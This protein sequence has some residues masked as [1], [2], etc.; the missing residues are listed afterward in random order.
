[1]DINLYCRTHDEAISLDTHLFTKETWGR[2]LEAEYHWLRGFREYI[3]D[4]NEFCEKHCRNDQCQVAIINEHGEE[5]WPENIA[6]KEISHYR[7]TGEARTVG[8]KII[9]A[10]V[11]QRKVKEKQKVKET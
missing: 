10:L 7:K 9:T 6:S 1:M 8:D 2:Y 3:F 4:L 11:M 5:L